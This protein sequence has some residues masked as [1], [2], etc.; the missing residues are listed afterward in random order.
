MKTQTS[1]RQSGA[2]LIAALIVLVILTSVAASVFMSSVPAYRGTYQASAW[3]E[4]KLAADAG[5]DFAMSELQKCAPNPRAFNWAGWTLPASAGGGSVPQD[6]DGER[7]YVA[8]DTT[9]VQGGD[10]STKP[11]ILEVRVDVMTRDDNFARNAWYRIRSTGVADVPNAQLSLDKRD[12]TLRKMTLQKKQITRTV[13]VIS[14]PVYLWEY[15]LKTN[16]SMVLGG[17]TDWRIDSY[18]SRYAT[19]S[20]NG[21]YAGSIARDFG[22][23]ASNR[24]LPEGTLFGILIDAEGAIVRGEVQTRGGDNPDTTVHENVEESQNIDQSRITDEF[25]EDL[26]EE[27]DPSWYVEDSGPT[28][29]VDQTG[30][31]TTT[32][33]RS[34]TGLYGQYD[35]EPYRVVIDWNGGQAM[36]GF[37]VVNDTASYDPTTGAFTPGSDRFVEIWIDGDVDLGGSQ[38]KVQKN[39][40][41][42]IYLNGNLNF[43]N[44]DINYISA[45]ADRPRYSMRPADLL[46]FGKLDAGST[47]APKV[48]SSGNGHI[49]AAFYGPQYAGNLDGNTEI[50]GSFVLNTYNIAGGGGSGGDSLGAGFHYDEALGVVGPVKSYRS[51]SYFEDTRFDFE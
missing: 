18:D 31:R 51:V 16:G 34:G 10:G 19:T 49:V 20:V 47:P 45:E 44:R 41:V 43:R 9:L 12:L 32:T 25:Y 27:P 28:G 4:A 14:R 39:V 17:G 42:K 46:I 35:Y 37:E 29:R 36:G 24:A 40:H 21:I 1:T 38:I 22:N 8:P 50:M 7:L 6:Y 5:V 30:D 26:T 11:R 33:I 3:A 48:D 23:I 15:A 13:E 2:A